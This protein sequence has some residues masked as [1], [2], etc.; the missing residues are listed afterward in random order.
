MN[1]GQMM[2]V[3]GAA[4]MFSLLTLSTN[5]GI[6]NSTRTISES[7]QVLTATQLGDGMIAE[8]ISKA[9]DAATADTFITNLN[10]LTAP[11]SLG[12]RSDEV[13]PNFNDVD[14]Y[15][16]LIRN[17][18]TPRMGVFCVEC[19]VCYVNDLNPNQVVWSK[20]AMKRIKVTVS[21]QNLP[22]SV[23]LYYYISYY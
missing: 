21:Q 15:H 11:G 13:Y 2:M 9:F 22:K 8:I 1:S 5:R 17:I 6:I 3:L 7:E 20:T 10:L 4:I 19:D 12:P 23:L 18:N 14:D 16:R